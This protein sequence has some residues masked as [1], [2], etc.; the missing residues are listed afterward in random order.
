MDSFSFSV[1]ALF[2]Y[3]TTSALFSGSYAAGGQFSLTA[4]MTNFSLFSIYD[5]YYAITGNSLIYPDVD[6]KFGSAEITLASGSGLTI[7]LTDVEVEGYVAAN[8]LLAI[9]PGGVTIRG[10]VTM[11][12][13]SLTFGELELKKAYIEISLR[14]NAED[15]G[16]VLGGEVAFSSFTLDALVH[17][18]RGKSGK[19]VEWTVFASLSAAGDTLAISKLVPEVKD[20][21]LDL[22][23]SEVVFVAASQEDPLVSSL[24]STKYKVHKGVQVCAMLSPIKELDSLMRSSTPMSGLVLS[25]GWSKGNGFTLDILMPAESVVYLGNGITTDPFALQIRAGTNKPALMLTAGVNIPVAPENEVL[26]FTLSLSIDPVGA[27]ATAQM[28]GNWVNPLGLG[29]KVVIG[30]DVA[31]SLEIIFAQFLAT[32]TPRYGDA[33]PLPY[34][35]DA[36]VSAVASVWSAVSPWARRPPRL[37]CRFQKTPPVSFETCMLSHDKSLH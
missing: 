18:Y 27:T 26:K 21:F 19:G 12:G 9:G 33:F 37:Q 25:A 7:A 36:K 20:T 8:A 30:P 11:T 3:G 35:P 22:T 4:L 24:V 31:L 23:L 29:K 16:V 5:I 28:H 17:L 32:G 2:E 14:K 15:S 34:S 1:S 10:D 13:A 6:V